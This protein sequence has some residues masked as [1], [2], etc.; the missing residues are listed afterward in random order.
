M[1]ADR[2]RRDDLLLGAWGPDADHAWLTGAA[3]TLLM[4]NR[5]DP[6]V[7]VPDPAL[8]AL[9]PA[10][11]DLGAIQG[12]GGVVW[13][14]AGQ[15]QVLRG[16]ADGWTLVDAGVHV[17]GMAAVAADDVVASSDGQSLMARWNGTAFVPEDSGSGTATP[18]LFQVPGGPVL[19][20]GIIG[21][22]L[23]HR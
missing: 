14:A 15:S 10:A 12:A 20:A 18:S 6:G 4:W 1:D 9:S 17:A 23:Q 3:G 11:A 22:I 16:T 7:A 8:P 19:A 2:H 5:T 13:I 21:G